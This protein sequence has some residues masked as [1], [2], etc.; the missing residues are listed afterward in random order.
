MEKDLQFKKLQ[1]DLD[2]QKKLRNDLEEE[3]LRLTAMNDEQK[4]V[5]KNLQAQITQ[6]EKQ[7]QYLRD[8][9]QCVEEDRLKLE[10]ISLRYIL[11]HL[12]LKILV[13]HKQN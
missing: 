13:E 12:S 11:L 3:V 8:S 4:K 7:Q 6:T 5:I 9:L 1:L 10:Q 2:M